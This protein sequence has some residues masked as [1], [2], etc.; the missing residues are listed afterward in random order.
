[1]IIKSYSDE[2]GIESKKK[3][4]LLMTGWSAGIK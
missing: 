1:M 2:V 4:R 3:V